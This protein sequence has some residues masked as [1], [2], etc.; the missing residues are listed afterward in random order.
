[1]ACYEPSESRLKCFLHYGSEDRLYV[2]ASSVKTTFD[3][4]KLRSVADI[5]SNEEAA[6]NIV[7]LIVKVFRG[8]YSVEPSASLFALALVVRKA[9]KNYKVVNEAYKAARKIS[10][11]NGEYFLTFTRYLRE[12]A[13]TE[14][15]KGFG[16]GWRVSVQKWYDSKDAMQLAQMV[17]KAYSIMNWSH[18]D[19]LALSRMKLPNDT[20]KAAVMCYV[21]KG[22]EAAFTKY[23]NVAEAKPVL[24]FLKSVDQIRRSETESVVINSINVHNF[25]IE[26]CPSRFFKSH[27]VW[28]ALIPRM[29]IDC[30]LSNIN[31]M[32]KLKLF[33]HRDVVR[34]VVSRFQRSDVVDVN[35]HPI[36]VYILRKRYELGPNLAIEFQYIQ[37]RRAI[38]NSMERGDDNSIQ[39][40][41]DQQVQRQPPP[42]RIPEIMECLTT[43]FNKSLA[44]LAPTGLRYLIALDSQAAMESRVCYKERFVTV[45][46]AASLVALC[47]I[48]AESESNVKLVTFTKEDS[49]VKEIPINKAEETLEGIKNKINRAESGPASLPQLIKWATSKQEVFDVIILLSDHSLVATG[50]YDALKTYR[51]KVSDKAKIITCSFSGLHKKYKELIKQ[52]MFFI[53][54]FDKNVGR[55]IE[56]YS[57]GAF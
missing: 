54:G 11:D 32:S 37:R 16:K 41:I 14:E 39:G 30:L 26:Y 7:P 6:K 27:E 33:R 8:G 12:I 50:S 3:V 53:C 46:E 2:P 1:M 22:Y 51:Q 19:I 28:L 23:S 56:A 13:Q 10:E 42:R 47:V 36:Y 4:S 34:E 52:D 17:T 57:R 48:K 5:L 49:G 43:L 29:S 31:R 38:E 45:E 9:K 20:A 24:E 55:L 15:K 35:I 44:L 40:D 18:K 25:S 21:S